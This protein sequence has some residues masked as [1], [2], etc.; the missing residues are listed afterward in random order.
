MF[1]EICIYEVKINKEE[2]FEDWEIETTLKVN[3]D[4]TI[5][6][7]PIKDSWSREE[8]HDLLG[9]HEYDKGIID[10]KNFI[11]EFCSEVNYPIV[12][13]WIEETVGVLYSNRQEVFTH[14]HI[15]TDKKDIFEE[16][17]LDYSLIKLF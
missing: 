6:I 9:Q 17:E 3:S 1:Y 13:N 7:K 10:W 16:I 8:L 15:K 14:L 4:N 12:E 2:E 5:S 11:L